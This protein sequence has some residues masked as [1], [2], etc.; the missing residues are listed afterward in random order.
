MKKS[1]TKIFKLFIINTITIIRLIGAFILPFIYSK[2]GSSIVSV[3]I[4][5]LFLTDAID[6][7][8]ARHLHAS[9][10]FGSILDGASDKILNAISFV[11]LGLHLL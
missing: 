11:I 2:Y 4:I 8:L 1:S 6:G 9:T 3:V 5:G 10:F 7:F